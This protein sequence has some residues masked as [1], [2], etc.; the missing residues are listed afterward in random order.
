MARAGVMVRSSVPGLAPRGKRCSMDQAYNTITAITLLGVAFL[1]LAARLFPQSTARLRP[2][3]AHV[4][5]PA[6][7]YAST[8]APASGA[9]GTAET[10]AAPTAATDLDP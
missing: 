6:N 2:A 1:L 10:P 3:Y 8:H 5:R 4:E 7:V 9:G